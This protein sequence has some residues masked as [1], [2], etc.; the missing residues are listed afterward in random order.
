M[1]Q[2]KIIGCSNKECVSPLQVRATVDTFHCSTTTKMATSEGFALPGVEEKEQGSKS[3]AAWLTNRREVREKVE[4]G[5]VSEEVGEKSSEGGTLSYSQKYERG[6]VI[7]HNFT[8][9][10]LVRDHALMSCR[11]KWPVTFPS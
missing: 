1:Q 6:G 10:N 2:N 11:L 3:R 8:S 4:A 7:G 5:S 9:L